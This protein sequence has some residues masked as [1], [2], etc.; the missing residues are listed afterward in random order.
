MEMEI[1]GKEVMQMKQKIRKIR[2]NT[3]GSSLVSVMVAFV[4]LMIGIAG[5]YASIRVS[6]NLLNRAEDLNTATGV[7]LQYFYENVKTD[8][9]ATA[10]EKATFQLIAEDAASGSTPL[11]TMEGFPKTATV[12]VA[13]RTDSSKTVTYSMYYYLRAAD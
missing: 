11:F 7:A 12:T 3:A 13:D 2:S 8:E 6:R 4:L 5:F 10:G 1:S 9:Y